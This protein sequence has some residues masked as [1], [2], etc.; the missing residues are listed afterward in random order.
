MGPQNYIYGSWSKSVCQKI[1]IFA[2]LQVL[3]I[4]VWTREKLEE[5]IQEA[6]VSFLLI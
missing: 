4:R 2:E 6:L 3:L 1:Q 5:E